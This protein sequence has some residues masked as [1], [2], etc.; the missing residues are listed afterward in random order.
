MRT[1]IGVCIGLFIVLFA[2]AAF[3]VLVRL[4]FWLM[5]IA[6][7]GGVIWFA[8]YEFKKYL[9]EKRNNKQEKSKRQN[10]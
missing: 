9:N 7:C 10:S 3:F 6:I 8:N 5:I 1:L 4:L 2:F